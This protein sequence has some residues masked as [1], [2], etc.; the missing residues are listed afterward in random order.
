MHKQ[1]M[2]RCIQSSKNCNT[3]KWWKSGIIL[4]L[5]FIEMSL[6]KGKSILIQDEAAIFPS[7]RTL[8]FKWGNLL[9]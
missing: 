7:S 3:E 8:Y 6:I 9:E 1:N 2:M 5:H 4:N